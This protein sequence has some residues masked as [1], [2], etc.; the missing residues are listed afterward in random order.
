[1][2][3]VLAI[4]VKRAHGGVMDAVPSAQLIAGKGLVGNADQGGKRQVTIIAEEAWKQAETKLGT[5]VDPRARRANLFVRGLDLERTRGRILLIGTCRLRVY[6]ETRPCE[7]MNKMHSGLQEALSSHWR[8][9]ISCEVLNDGEIK[10][11]DSVDWST[12]ER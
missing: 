6:S 8:A 3:I 7:L 4:W 5:E 10:I 1:M 9:G 11:G 12:D 2:G